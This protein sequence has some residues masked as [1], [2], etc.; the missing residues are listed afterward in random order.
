[1]TARRSCLLATFSF[2]SFLAVTIAC[3]KTSGDAAADD[4]H[5]GPTGD[6]TPPVRQTSRKE[7]PT[8]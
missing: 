6:L 3:T 5:Q 8:R 1:M 7:R 4:D 2:A